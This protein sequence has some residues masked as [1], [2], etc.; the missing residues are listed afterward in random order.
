VA[1]RI[2]ERMILRRSESTPLAVVPKVAGGE[3]R[4]HPAAAT[5]T[6]NARGLA[7][8]QEFGDDKIEVAPTSAALLP[9]RDLVLTKLLVGL[10][11]GS[12]GSIASGGSWFE[13]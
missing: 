12:V 6:C 10:I 13:S 4:S 8:G 3:M 5:T 2:E 7:E 9:A 11:P 1:V